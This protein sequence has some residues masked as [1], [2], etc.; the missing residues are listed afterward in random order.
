MRLTRTQQIYAAICL[1][2]IVCLL[3]PA[4]NGWVVSWRWYP[5]DGRVDW[6][7]A[8][9]FLA[10]INPY[11]PQAL[12]AVGIPSLGH[13]P[14]TGFWMLPFAEYA[15]EDMSVIYGHVVLLL[16]FATLLLVV[17]E[18]RWPLPTLTAAV[19]FFATTTTGWFRYSL[20][21][22]QIGA[23]LA[24]A[25][26]LAWVLL[27]R[28]HDIAA[29]CVLGLACTIKLHPGLMVVF[30]LLARRT[31]AV[32][33]AAV[34]YLAVAALMT[35]RMGLIAWVQYGRAEGPVMERW[36]GDLH[37][38]SLYGVVMRALTPSCQGRGV[39]TPMTTAIVVAI[40]LVAGLGAWWL[41]RKALRQP[42]SLNLAYALFVVLSVFL[43]P[44]VF[45]HYFLQLVLPFLV[46]VTELG[47]A[48][49]RGLSAWWAGAGVFA[50]V[51]IAV[52]L[53]IDPFTKDAINPMV[54][55]V[56]FHL[57]EV[58]N[59]LHI[60]VLGVLLAALLAWFE[61]HRVKPAG[62]AI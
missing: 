60:V 37:N 52:M 19:L 47:V 26:A 33:A 55:H 39:P 6:L 50:V 29:G 23:L 51:A 13:P 2:G 28:G 14:T 24:I 3:R 27:R 62:P 59:W 20:M 10:G 48:Y 11:S 34:A 49:R 18:L 8:R 21:V 12:E 57:Y 4:I 44:F 22:A 7:V 41:S 32:A 36:A 31:R 35:S 9:G 16:V 45:E 17:R 58:M 61:R 30:L 43:N 54:A 15:I 25:V 53:A 46:A 56:R 1:I 5:F 42:P 40:A 38:A